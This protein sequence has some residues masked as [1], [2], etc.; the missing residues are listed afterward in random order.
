MKSSITPTFIRLSLMM[1]LQYILYAVW[2]VPFA[3]YLANINVVGIQNALMLSSMAIGTL[4]SPL[5]GMVAD[6]YFS[7]EKLLAIINSI[8]TALLLLA[9]FVTN[10]NLLLLIL[11]LSMLLYMPTW[12]LVSSIAMTHTPSEQFPRI[13]VFGSIGWVASGIFSLIAVKLFNIDFDGTNIPFFIASGISLVTVLSNFTLPKTPPP[14]KGKKGSLV[15]AFGLRTLN[16]M[17]DRN[18]VIFIILSFLSVLPF[19][20]YF[21][22]GS[23]FLLDKKFNLITVTMNWGQ[24]GEIF[25]MVTIPFLINKIGIKYT[26]ALGLLA[27]FIRY[28]SFYFG[29]AE[30]FSGLYFVGILIHGFIFGYLYVGGQIYI[31]KKAPAELRAQTQGF[32]FLVNFGLGLL[33]GNFISRLIIESYSWR[34]GN[35][36]MYN[37]DA[38]WGITAIMSLVIL[39]LFLFFFKNSSVKSNDVK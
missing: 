6:R 3:A 26:I 19:S 29:S 34:E 35:S 8:N 15:D 36:T 23:E 9:G 12:S 1:F 31:D 25:I 17:S 2:W 16:L 14:S 5:V 24:L 37:W 39:L 7:S 20:M 38:I 28:L 18:F 10:Q 13:R 27:L 11:L 4:A 33:I 32:F 30:G 21:S 22:Y